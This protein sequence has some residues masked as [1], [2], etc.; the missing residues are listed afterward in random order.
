MSVPLGTVAGRL[1]G[2]R[3]AGGR[4]SLDSGLGAR[5]LANLPGDL[6]R[7][8][9]LAVRLRL[10]ERPAAVQDLGARPIQTYEV[11]PALRDRQTVGRGGIATAELHGDRPVRV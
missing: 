3:G 7:H 4:L 1:P 5:R 6:A 8:F 2:C 9:A 10:R 11:V